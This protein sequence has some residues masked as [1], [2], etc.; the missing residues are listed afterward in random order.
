MGFT[1][2]EEKMCIITVMTVIGLDK[3]SGFKHRSKSFL[4]KNVSF[5]LFERSCV[6]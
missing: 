6:L 2:N 3:T 4:E 1:Q 5:P